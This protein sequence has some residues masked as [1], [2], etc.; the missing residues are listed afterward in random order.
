MSMAVVK[1][2]AGQGVSAPEVSVEVH[3]ANGLPAFQLVGMAETS[4]KEARERV[5]SALINSGFDFPAKRITVNLAPADI[6]K[7]GGRFDLP[8]AV[9]ILVA[10]GYLPDTCLYDIALVG[11]LGLNGE[12]K[13]VGGLI[14]ILMASAHEGLPLIFPG[15]NVSAFVLTDLL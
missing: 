13:S 5:R 10:S 8:I 14:P 2:F 15:V 7:Y 11:E 9:G 6:P 4:V 12:I 3:L 1:T